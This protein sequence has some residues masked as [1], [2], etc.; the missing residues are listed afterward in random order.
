MS[1]IVDHR[2]VSAWSR[3]SVLEGQTVGS[4]A[5]HVGWGTVTLVETVLDQPAPA[6]PRDVDTAAEYDALALEQVTADGH[7]AIRDRGAELAAGGPGEL[8]ELVRG[9]LDR[10]R[11]R[12]PAVDAER[13]IEAFGGY[14]I[15][16]DD[17]L[18]T[19]LV[20]QVVHLDD[21]ARSIGVDPWPNPPDAEALVVAFGAEVGRRRRGATAMIRALYRGAEEGT[22]PVM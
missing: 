11:V 16:F 1:A 7:G 2:V 5:C 20:E 14:T 4:V 18:W 10:L 17:Y 12:L 9:S 15:R 8:A 21:L 13:T 3:P 6:G 19:R 22:L